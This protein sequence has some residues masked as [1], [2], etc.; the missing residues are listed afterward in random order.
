MNLLDRQNLVSN[1]VK[2]E[3]SELSRMDSVQRSVRLMD[4]AENHKPMS[5]L[6]SFDCVRDSEYLTFLRGKL[7][8]AVNND[9]ASKIFETIEKTIAAHLVSIAGKAF[10]DC[11]RS[12]S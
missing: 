1:E 10:N 9:A 4:I 6:Q 12:M 7:C 5:I 2:S 8:R 3:F 11:K